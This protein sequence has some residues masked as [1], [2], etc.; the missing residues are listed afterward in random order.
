MYTPNCE[1]KPGMEVPKQMGRIAAVIEY[2]G[3]SFRGFQKQA[4]TA[5]TVQGHL[6]QALSRIANESVTLVCAGRT[7][8]G[9]H[10][11][12][13]VI[14]FDTSAE[15]PNK[16]WVAGVNTQLPKTIRVKH[17]LPVDFSF[18]ARFCALART[19]RY[20]T[21]LQTL[22]SALLNGLATW[23]K[24]SLNLEQMQA[25]AQLLVGEHDFSA[26]RASQ[27]QA[28]SPVRRVEYIKL[29]AK[30]E[31]LV[32]EIKAN[33]FLHHMVRNTMGA[34][35]EVG[36]GAKPVDWIA[37]VL[38]SR[39]RSQNASTAPPDGL[40]FVGVDYPEQY[41]PLATPSGPVFCPID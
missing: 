24:Y 34:L 16:A 2:N 26:F 29:L 35:F 5:N 18:H 1:I 20:I 7:D 25:A 40:Y 27:C 36:R 30:G 32:M 8:A 39:D 15:R 4:S 33:A 21:S 14:H 31:L 22:P 13:Q 38:A 3:A 10:A 9:V 6:E 41:P 17:A 37:E 28:K 19:Y 12:Q 23:Q 11:T